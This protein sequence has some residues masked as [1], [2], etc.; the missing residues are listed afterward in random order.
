MTRLWITWPGFPL[1][2]LAEIFRSQS[3]LIYLLRQEYQTLITKKP[4]YR[5]LIKYIQ[6]D[7][8]REVRLDDVCREL[9]VSAMT[10]HRRLKEETQH[11]FK[12]LVTYIRVQHAIE[13]MRT[14]NDNMEGV[15]YTVG[16]Q[17]AAAFSYA[18]KRMTG[19][20][21]KVMCDELREQ[22]ATR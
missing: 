11:N 20:T 14:C 8:C 2:K 12:Y 5:K 19:K 10:L 17:S 13:L 21:P 1:Y 4:Y 3:C 22:K 9:G 6:E 16:Y 15:G 7:W 18:F